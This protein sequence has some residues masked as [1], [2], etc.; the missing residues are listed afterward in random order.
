VKDSLNELEPANTLAPQVDLHFSLSPD[1]HSYLSRQLASYPFHVGR[2]L[3]KSHIPPAMAMCYLQCSSGGLFEHDRIRMQIIAEQ[4]AQ[5]SVH[6]AA[7]TVVHSMPRG[8]A[9]YQM[10]LHAQH[11]AYLEYNANLNILFPQSRLRNHIDIHLQPDAFV[12]VA[13]AYLAHDPQLAGQRFTQLDSRISALDHEHNLLMRDHLI[14]NGE[15]LAQQLNAI[16]PDFDTMGSIYLLKQ[17]CSQQEITTLQTIAQHS[18]AQLEPG[19]AWVGTGPLPHQCGVSLRIL[20]NSGA[21]LQRLLAEMSSQLH[22][23]YL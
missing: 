23:L 20:A 2:L 21:P 13:D 14:L 18:I 5:A 8:E 10:A 22:K 7:A 17:N 12:L 6:H 1:G 9:H 4:G 3:K 11:N 19:C 16:H 15:Q